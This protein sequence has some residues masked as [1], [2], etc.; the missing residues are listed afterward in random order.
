MSGQLY[1][2]STDSES[3]SELDE[4]FLGRKGEG[5]Y[6]ILPL[7]TSSHRGGGETR[8]HILGKHYDPHSPLQPINYEW[9]LSDHPLSQPH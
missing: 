1:Q 7:S 3:Y 9:S 2:L 4:S 6:G 8:K 5:G